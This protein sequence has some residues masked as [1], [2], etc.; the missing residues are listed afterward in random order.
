MKIIKYLFFLLLLLFIG[1]AIYFGTK[2]GSYEIQSVKKIDAHP[3]LLFTKINNLESWKDWS[4]WKKED[5]DDIF[6]TA[7]KSSGEGASANWDKKEKGHIETMKVIPNSEID[8]ILTQQSFGGEQVSNVA[9]KFEQIPNGTE[10]TW[11]IRGKHNLLSKI[12]LA[13]KNNNFN[14]NLYA[15]MQTA[16]NNLEKEIHQ[17]IKKYT[18]HV[19]GI[20]HYGGG[21]YL[22]MTS[23]GK[24]SEVHNLIKPMMTEL[25]KFMENNNISSAGSPFVLYNELDEESKTAIFSIGFPVRERIITPEDSHI[26]SGFMEPVSAVK[27]TLK[28]NYE[29][30]SETYN[31]AELYLGTNGYERDETRKVFEVYLTNPSEVHNPAEWV[32]EI[33]IP[34]ESENSE[35]EI[36]N[37]ENEEQII[38]AE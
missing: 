25:S 3:E 1:T 33:Y 24:Q 20:T 36:T 21:Y 26:V 15:K 9:W 34:V 8:Q 35:N 10:I 17:D 4:P 28:G 18:I 11:T 23:A 5:P 37:P 31:N 12:Y 27:T 13:I 7:E 38:I 22:Y 16:L 29:N 6:T 2:D 19:D 32:T 14:K 30:I